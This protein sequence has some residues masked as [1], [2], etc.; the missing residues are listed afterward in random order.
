MDLKST[1]SEAWMMDRYAALMREHHFHVKNLQRIEIYLKKI[2]EEMTKKK[3]VGTHYEETKKI[4]NS[5]DCQ[6]IEHNA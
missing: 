1:V 4:E 5:Q 2:E 3:K 6:E